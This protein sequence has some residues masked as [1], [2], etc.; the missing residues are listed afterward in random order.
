MPEL[1]KLLEI[2]LRALSDRG[3]FALL[4]Q[5]DIIIYIGMVWSLKSRRAIFILVFEQQFCCL[6]SNIVPNN[7]NIAVTSIE[8]LVRKVPLNTRSEEKN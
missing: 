3:G 5:V 2:V 8:S 4:W 1:R 6:N 7:S